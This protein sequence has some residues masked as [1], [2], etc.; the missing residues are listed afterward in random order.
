MT[1]EDIDNLLD[2]MAKEAADKGDE[3][4][5]P[6]AISMSVDSYFA[7]PRGAAGCSNILHGIRY[8]G[9]QILV[10]R[11][12]ENRVMNRAEDGGQGAPYFDLQ[13]KAT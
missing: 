10:A 2:L 7:L 9:V 1:L 8:R 11:A 12:R 3:A 6:G 4:F 5:Q 13:P